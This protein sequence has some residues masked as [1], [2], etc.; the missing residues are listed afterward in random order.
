MLIRG[1]LILL[2]CQSW[3]LFAQ[4]RTE[5]H[6]LDR[7]TIK[8]KASR[9]SIKKCFQKET[10]IG[11]FNMAGYIGVA[12]KDTVLRRKQK[13]IYYEAHHQFKRVG[14]TNLDSKK[15][16][17]TNTKD[18]NQAI[19]EVDQQITFLENNGYPF[20]ALEI[21]SMEE[22]GKQL[23]VA[24]KIDSGDVCIIDEIHLKSEDPF[25]EKIILTL[26]GLKPGMP[27]DE[28]KIRQIPEIFLNSQ[29]YTSPKAPEILFRPGKAELFVY[30]NKK[31]SSTADGFV[32]FQQD[33]IT[34]R[35]VLN[36]YINLQL[37]NALNRGETMHLHWRNNPNSTQNL[38][39][40]FELPYFFGTPFG[41]GAFIDL[42]QQDASFV[43]S[44]I[45]LEAIY[46]NT[47]L[48]A[49]VFSQFETS[50]TISQ[51]PI[52]GFRDFRK[53]TV[54]STFRYKPLLAESF[55]H[56]SFFISGGIF[57][58]QEDSLENEPNTLGNRK[59]AIEYH[60]DIDFLKY[61]QLRNTIR[62][63]GLKSTLNLARNEY[64]FFGGLQSVRGFYEL[65]LAAREAWIMR[66]EITF[67]PIK[68]LSIKAIYDYANYV[69][70][71]KRWAHALGFGFGF[72]TGNS[73][74]EIIVANGK[75]DSNPFILS[76]TKV[77]IG[78]RSNF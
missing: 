72:Q 54:G 2:I 48:R 3:T 19:L 63:E 24:Y 26:L 5:Y 75:L 25:Q 76:E 14:L 64:I 33:R 45:L 15:K 4:D 44:D 59:Y 47:R 17:T 22:D 16:K 36:G 42:Q 58:Y 67:T 74:L 53:N 52:S 7:M 39:G 37:Q 21:T 57:R 50:N 10:I 13:H 9:D 12:V 55:Y 31:K 73:H 70:Q 66:N 11:Q 30:F 56:P 46:I 32:G 65:E 43:R 8:L 78:F 28:S 35:L 69:E 1:F 40:H 51:V 61:F 41:I 60:Q 68:S 49:S 29:L 18:L 62:Y 20:A 23:N 6:H 71:S 38:K 27:Y 34:D 77:H